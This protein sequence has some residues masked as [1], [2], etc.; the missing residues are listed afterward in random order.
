M[1]ESMPPSR[2]SGCTTSSSSTLSRCGTWRVPRLPWRRVRTFEPAALDAVAAR[3]DALG[4]LA[5]V[6]Q[7]MAREV[8][9][10][11]RALKEKVKQLRIEIDQAHASQQLDAITETD[12]FREL[13]RRVDELRAR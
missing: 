8:N 2:G 1:R 11:E 12:Y 9:A 5:R 3:E 6:F 7:R 13:E 10:R 4:R